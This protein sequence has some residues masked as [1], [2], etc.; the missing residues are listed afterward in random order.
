MEEK[1]ILQVVQISEVVHQALITVQRNF[2]IQGLKGIQ[3]R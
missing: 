3:R 2:N 1:E